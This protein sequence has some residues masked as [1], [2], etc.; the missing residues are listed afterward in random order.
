MLC[1]CLVVFGCVIFVELLVASVLASMRWLLCGDD[2]TKTRTKSVIPK[3]N[4]PRENFFHCRYIII[5]KKRIKLQSL[6]ISIN[7]KNN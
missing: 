3:K 2:S 5:R 6:Q 7:S 1:L 4:N